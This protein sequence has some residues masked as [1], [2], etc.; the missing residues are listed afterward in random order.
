MGQLDG[1]VAIVTGGGSGIG[2]G[3]VDRYVEEGARVAVVDIVQERLDDVHAQHGDNTIGI[4]G[5]VTKMEDNQRAVAETVSAFGKLD[6]FVANA[7]LGDAF[8]EL[9]DIA[10]ED[11][12]KTYREIYDL[13][14]M[15]VIMG[16]RAA[17]AELVKTRGNFIITLSNSS[18]YPDGGGV[19]YIG[20][21][22]G[23][24]GVM[25]QLAHEF[26]P[27]V[28]VNAV[29]PGATRTDIRMP[30]SFGLD[31]N[32]QRIRTHTHP[33]NK[34][35]AVEAVVPLALHADPEQHS[36]A[37]VLLA[38]RRDGVVISGACIKTD[39]GLGIRGLRRVRG[40]DDLAERL[41][42]AVA[43]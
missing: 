23:A 9:I 16:A 25:R 3:V 28:R 11:V 27:H 7:G 40:G 20:S 31:E 26:A 30:A 36:G 12:E 19:M 35:E 2:R 32:G 1:Q 42:V 39:A 6:T 8:R 15:A 21:K 10:P 13:N 17:V 41:G 33:S 5:D 43:T 29:G 34:D 18:F 37:Y 4:L 22:H 38:S 24:L 14:I